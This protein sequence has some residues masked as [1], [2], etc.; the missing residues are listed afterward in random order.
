MSSSKGSL[1]TPACLTHTSLLYILQICYSNHL[2]N[3]TKRKKKSQR[4]TPLRQKRNGILIQTSWRNRCLK[5][6]EVAQSCPDSLQP[7]GL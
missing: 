1:Y 6:G 2:R 3:S 7:H 5:N 4:F